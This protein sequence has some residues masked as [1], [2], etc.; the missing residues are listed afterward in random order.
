MCTC[1]KDPWLFFPFILEWNGYTAPLPKRLHGACKEA[2]RCT[3]D[4][5]HKMRN[6]MQYTLE[7]GPQEMSCEG[8]PIYVG[9]N[10]HGTRYLR[11]KLVAVHAGNTESATS[12]KRRECYESPEEDERDSNENEIQHRYV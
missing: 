4:T 5:Q 10:K 7:H 3:D 1:L 9:S 6:I 8:S 2:L 11:I 12:F